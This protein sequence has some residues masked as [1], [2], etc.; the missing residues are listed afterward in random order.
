MAQEGTKSAEW[1]SPHWEKQ[2]ADMQSPGWGQGLFLDSQ[3][4]LLSS[5]LSRAQ[6]SVEA[7]KA[8]GQH[9]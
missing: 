6:E 2:A 7:W 9:L 3:A 1:V 5:L 8:R 4:S